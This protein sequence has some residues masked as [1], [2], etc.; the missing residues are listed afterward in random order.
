MVYNG[1][2][3]LGAR[4]TYHESNTKVSQAP[5]PTSVLDM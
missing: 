1:V 3:W 2:R 4:L 5:P